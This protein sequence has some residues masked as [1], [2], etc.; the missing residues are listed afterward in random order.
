MEVTSQRLAEQ[1][2]DRTS[3]RRLIDDH[4]RIAERC[5]D[6]VALLQRRGHNCAAASRKLL[7]LAVL[8]ADH[9]GVEDEVIDLTAI[10]TEADYSPE[11]VAVMAAELDALR[12]EWRVFIAHWL[13]TIEPADWYE[14][15]GE[16]EAML[17]RLT[18]QVQRESALLYDD[19]LRAG[20]IATGPVDLQ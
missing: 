12:R 17:S 18:H 4:D 1:R 16:A 9:L 8:V 19:A 20:V 11:T 15:R 2:D 3:W 10:A 5:T 6:L 13:P 7:E 14:F